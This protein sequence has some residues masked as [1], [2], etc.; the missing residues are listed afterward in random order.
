SYSADTSN[1]AMAVDSS[2]NLFAIYTGTLAQGANALVTISYALS[3]G[4]NT[5]TGGSIAVTVTGNGSGNLELTYDQYVAL[6]AA[7]YDSTDFD[8]AFDQI[9]V[10]CTAAEFDAEI[11]LNP[12]T[13]S[14][15]GLTDVTIS[16]GA[17]VNMSFYAGIFL[18]THDVTIAGASAVNVELAA[19]DVT[20][21]ETEDAN[22]STYFGTLFSYFAALGVTH[23]VLADGS[24]IQLSLA[25][26]TALADNGI[27]ISTTGTVTLA[28][29]AADVAGLTSS[30]VAN[31]AAVGVGR[32]DTTDDNLALSAGLAAKLAA[33]GLVFAEA[34]TVSVTGSLAAVNALIV[35]SGDAI[36]AL[37]IDALN[38]E[39]LATNIKALSLAEIAALGDA[40]VTEIDLLDDAATLAASQIAAFTAAGIDFAADDVITEKAVPVAVADS[41]TA[42]QHK[43]ATVSVLAND[44]A[45]DGYTLSVDDATVTSSNGTATL[46]AQGAL[47]V[48]YTGA[49]IDRGETAAVVVSYTIDDGYDSAT[50]TL[51]VTFNGVNEDGDILRGTSGTD[52]LRG[53][54][55]KDVILGLAGGDFLYGNGGNDRLDGGA[56]KDVLV[57]GAGADILIGGAGNDVLSG[58]A[59]ADTFLFGKTSGHDTITDFAHGT[60]RIDLSAVT[61]ITDFKDLRLHHVVDHGSSIEIVWGNHSVLLNGINDISKL[62]GSDF[63]FG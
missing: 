16:D 38:V 31:L 53:T 63:L 9:T 7:G 50:G 35:A 18:A 23:L 56:G 62:S 42:D 49:D 57:G 33:A 2:G 61:A 58:G 40:G 51:T 52:T 45:A 30:D 6:A 13:A 39:D 48:S 12:Q 44:T 54:G 21:F 59:G 10:S 28:D 32:I 19:E 5:T 29:D 15:F 25:P 4:T 55:I 43:T 26:Y 41:A 47:V 34:D 24:D 27:A 36:A 3:D 8:A 17:S 14:S 60:D 22:A 1:I 20:G 37:N 11:G 46:N